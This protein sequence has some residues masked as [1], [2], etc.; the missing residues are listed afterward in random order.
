MV[1]CGNK[2][3]WANQTHHTPHI[4]IQSGPSYI[5]DCVTT[6]TKVCFRKLPNNVVVLADYYAL[7]DDHNHLNPTI[8][9]KPASGSSAELIFSL[10]I[11]S[12]VV[13]TRTIP[14]LFC[15]LGHEQK[16]SLPSAIKGFL[17]IWG[18]PHITKENMTWSWELNYCEWKT[19]IAAAKD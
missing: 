3:Q 8:S 13:G 7:S 10:K 12:V 16:D 15:G 4:F 19:G 17:T 11:T 6:G 9:V 2:A 14:F 1:C 18:H 5:V